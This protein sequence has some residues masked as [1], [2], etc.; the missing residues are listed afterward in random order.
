[1]KGIENLRPFRKGDGRAS[2]AGR[3]GGKARA[4]VVAERKTFREYAEAM[5]DVVAAKRGKY[6]GLSHGAR[7]VAK[8]YD[9]AER[10]NVK[11]AKAI[12]EL[13]GEMAKRIEVA[14]LPTIIDDVPRAPDPA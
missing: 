1:M 6:A 11:A 3:K 4:T 7:V 12:F 9:A 8:L 13:T 10:G 14:Q 5:R 2:E